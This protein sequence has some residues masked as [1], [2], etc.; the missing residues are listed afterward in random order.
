MRSMLLVFAALAGHRR[1]RLFDGQGQLLRTFHDE[2]S[3]PAQQV[4]ELLSVEGGAY[5]LT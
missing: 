4:L 5:G 2:V 3:E 1:H